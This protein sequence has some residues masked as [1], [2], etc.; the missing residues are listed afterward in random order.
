[1]SIPTP[2]FLNTLFRKSGSARDQSPS[3]KAWIT[4]LASSRSN[5][6]FFI[7]RCLLL[8]V[9]HDLLAADAKI[10]CTTPNG[11]LS[12][13]QSLYGKCVKTCRPARNWS[14]RAVFKHRRQIC[15]PRNFLPCF[16]SLILGTPEDKAEAFSIRRSCIAAPAPAP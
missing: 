3:L 1:M 7:F 13:A 4:T 6:N 14:L 12:S 11:D 9:F 15:R 16:V 8:D 2:D 5:L 10:F